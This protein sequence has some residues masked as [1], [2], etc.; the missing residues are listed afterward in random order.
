MQVISVS[1]LKYGYCG[2]HWILWISLDLTLK[3]S[4][5]QVISLDTVDLRYQDGFFA[6]G[7]FATQ[8]FFAGPTR[9]G[10]LWFS[11]FSAIKCAGLWFERCPGCMPLRPAPILK[12]CG[13]FVQGALLRPVPV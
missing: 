10:S 7:R 13:S 9:V 3:Y 1:A 5:M 6:G 11:T 12:G 2:S 4:C 8:R